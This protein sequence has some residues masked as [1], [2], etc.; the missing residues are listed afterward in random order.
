MR[1][2]LSASLLSL[3]MISLLTGCVATTSDMEMLNSRLDVLDSRIARINEKLQLMEHRMVT[4]ENA[5]KVETSNLADTRAAMDQMQDDVRYIKGS[6][7]AQ[8]RELA[9]LKEHVNRTESAVSDLNQTVMKMQRERERQEPQKLY[10][11]AL[12]LFRGGQYLDAMETF[13]KFLKDFPEHPL[14][15]NSQYWMGECLLAMKKPRKAIL[16][17]DKVVKGYPNSPKV[18]S[19][20]LKEAI[21]FLSLRN[22]KVATILLKRLINEYPKTEQAKIAVKKLKS[23]TPKPKSRKERSVTKPHPS[24]TK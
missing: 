22:K 4:L 10:N 8:R 17:F 6:L 3:L 9:I 24:K 23:I 19:A 5:K 13:E 21:S 11:T 15:G 7:E 20:L 2:K 16:A 12:Q 14:A 1:C 18:P